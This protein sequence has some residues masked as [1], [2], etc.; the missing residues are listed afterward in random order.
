MFFFGYLFVGERFTKD[1]LLST[2]LGI[3]GL[4]FVFSPDI[5]TMRWIALGAA[6]ISGLG[7]AA[8]SVFAKK[9]SYNPTQS[10]ISVWVTSVAANIFMAVLIGEKSPAIGWHVQWLYLVFFAIASV[11]SSYTL[12]KGLKLIEAGAA[13]ILGLLE[14]VFGVLFGLIFFDERIGGIIWL[15]L[16]TIIVSAAIPY[17]KDYKAK[18]GTL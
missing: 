10:T 1:K 3:I 7:C 16:I 14:I 13:G 15:G 8:N 12:I 11:C 18:Q 4:F 2:I 6:I 17:I 5:S 9:I